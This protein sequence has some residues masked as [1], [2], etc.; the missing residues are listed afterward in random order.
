MVWWRNGH[1]QI[2]HGVGRNSPSFGRIKMCRSYAFPQLDEDVMASEDSWL[3]VV[4]KLQAG[5]WASLDDFE[6]AAAAKKAKADAEAEKIAAA[7]EA[8]RLAVV[9]EARKAVWVDV[10]DAIVLIQQELDVTQFDAQESLITACASREVWFRFVRPSGSETG[11]CFVDPRWWQP[12]LRGLLIQGGEFRQTFLEITEAELAHFF[13]NVDQL[14]AWLTK[15]GWAAERGAI[16][17]NYLTGD[18]ISKSWYHAAG[19]LAN[20]EARATGHDDSDELQMAPTAMID[21]EISDAYSAAERARQKP[22][23][24]KEIAKVVQD[25]MLAKG[26]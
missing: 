13:I 2:N 3:Q 15:R 17:W 21:A 25:R 10:S 6:A 5:S 12:S 16:K 11:L 20:P 4:E 7:K 23:N 26:Y 14:L 24:I 18:Y 1:F 9:A 19:N 22:P 8:K